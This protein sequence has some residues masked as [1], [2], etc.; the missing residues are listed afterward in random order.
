[1]LQPR[2]ASESLHPTLQI[3]RKLGRPP[4]LWSKRL[5]DGCERQLVLGRNIAFHALPS[6]LSS[7][8]CPQSTP[9]RGVLLS[10]GPCFGALQFV[11]SPA[12]FLNPCGPCTV[13]VAA[14][15]FCGSDWGSRCFGCLVD[16]YRLP[17]VNI[18]GRSTPFNE[19]QFYHAEVSQKT[20]FRM[21][22]EQT[23]AQFPVHLY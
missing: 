23:D 17:T 7:G 6:L 14:S 13:G 4:R 2:S 18:R 15:L 22:I 11:V 20:R 5:R 10:V 3:T 16:I 9:G 8:T 1:M 19:A 12:I 21:K